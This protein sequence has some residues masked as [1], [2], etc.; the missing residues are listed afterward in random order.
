VTPQNQQ[1]QQPISPVTGGA[2]TVREQ[3]KVHL[4]LAYLGILSLI[5]LLT[6]K[7][8]DF[9]KWHARQ[10]LVLTIGMTV[11][12]VVFSAI[13]FPIACLLFVAWGVFSIMG[14]TRGLKGERWRIPLAADLSEKF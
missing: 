2:E 7:D 10:G 5:P 1:E 3:D 6:V 4:V 12:W 11:G 14:I 8:S 13:F 9:V